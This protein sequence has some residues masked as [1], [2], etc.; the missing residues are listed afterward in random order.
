MDEKADLALVVLSSSEL[1]T[2]EGLREMFRRE[3]R[4]VECGTQGRGGG[5][6]RRGSVARLGYR[7]ETAGSTRTLRD[8]LLLLLQWTSE[9]L[10]VERRELTTG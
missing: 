6:S 9:D 10:F 5:A 3:L 1:D 7:R 4:S 8:T 2:D